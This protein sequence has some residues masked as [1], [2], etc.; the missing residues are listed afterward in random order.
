MDDG[1]LTRLFEQALSLTGAERRRFLDQLSSEQREQL[2]PL[3]QADQSAENHGLY[4]N[5]IAPAASPDP[6]DTAAMRN[7]DSAQITI[8]LPKQIGRYKI[9]QLIAEGGM[10]SVFMAEQTEPVKRRVALKIIKAGLD[11]E[12]V[13]ARFEAERQA[14]AMM[15]HAH[16]AKV[17][18]AGVTEEGLPFFVM[19]LVSGVSITTYC[20]E[21]RLNPEQR[22]RLFIQVCRAIQHAHQKGIIH[23]DIKPSN[24]LVTQAD[25]VPIPKVI[26]FGLAK[27]LQSDTLTDRTLFTHFGQVMGTLEYMSPEQAEMNSRDIDTRSDVYSLGVLLYELLTGSTPIGRER[28]RNEAFQQVMRLIREEE[29]QRPSLRLS[30]SGDAIIGI[31]EQRGIEPKQLNTI[32]RGDLDW[33]AVKALE[34]DRHR[35]YDGAAALASDVERFLN[36]EPIEAR[37][38]SFLYRLHKTWRRHR[39]AFASAAS[40]IVLLIAGLISTGTLWLRART[41]EQDATNQAAEAGR[42]KTAAIAET[43]KT[44]FALAQVEEERQRATSAQRETEAALARSDY[45]LAFTRWQARLFDESLRYLE[46]IPTEHRN[47]EWR[48]LRHTLEG[49]GIDCIGHNGL[50]TS[51][52]YSPDGNTLASG[53][54]DGTVRIWDTS[55]GDVLLTIPDHPTATMALSPDGTTLATAWKTI[56]FWDLRTGQQTGKLPEQSNLIDSLQ[57]NADGTQILSASRTATTLWSIANGTPIRSFRQDEPYFHQAVL[58]PDGRTIAAEGYSSLRTWDVES[59]KATSM[60]GRTGTAESV[61]FTPSG[62]AVAWINM[63]SIKVGEPASSRVQSVETYGKPRRLRV[64]PDGKYIGSVS[65]AGQIRIWH[66]HQL[67][68]LPALGQLGDGGLIEFSP[69][70]RRVACSSGSRIQIMPIMPP[71]GRKLRGRGSMMVTSVSGSPDGQL[72]AL[73]ESPFTEDVPKQITVWDTQRERMVCAIDA[74]EYRIWGTAFRNADEL[75][76]G[77]QTKTNFYDARS[78][79]LLRSLSQDTKAAPRIAISPDRQMLAVGEK[80]GDVSI[81][82]LSNNTIVRTLGIDEGVWRLTFSSDNRSMAV[83]NDSAISV[84]DVKSG[85][86]RQTLHPQFPVTLIGFSPTDDR[87][88]VAFEQTGE[89]EILSLDGSE[90]VTLDE[91][92]GIASASFSSDGQ[93]L[94]S[95]GNQTI[96]IYHAKSGE[97]LC[98]IKA[99]GGFENALLCGEAV[100]GVGSRGSITSWPVPARNRLKI[101]AGHKKDVFES[102]LSADGRRVYSSSRPVSGQELIVWDRASGEEI[103]DARWL[104]TDKTTSA[105]GRW[106]VAHAGKNVLLIDLEQ[107]N[108]PEARARRIADAR[109]NP[110]WHDARAT[111]AEREADWF[112]AAFHRA[113]QFKLQPASKAAFDKLH[114]AHA[115]LRASGTTV[116]PPITV[117]AL[118]FPEPDAP[119]E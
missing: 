116:I 95:A 75:A 18:D 22:L 28:V 21:A 11:T 118:K 48:W 81:W 60:F 110:Q 33:I 102:H 46:K 43:E 83:A 59:G 119:S 49:D 16:I 106:Q 26:D 90:S 96:R 13:T 111:L 19:E 67:V 79:K 58:S 84:W 94:L 15:A 31:S 89:L 78:G 66:R 62:N 17:F 69:D 88:V 92:R 74:P 34:K 54:N 91:H 3:L 32:V 2:E 101:L 57:F 39:L 87:L 44:K 108:S 104:R 105:D 6:G 82:D 40:L 23:R 50:I 45:R 71:L 14:M 1:Q 80:E 25:G 20:D 38:P 12:Q 99:S 56:S 41:A 117:E 47:I 35:R 107:W 24:V 114:Q 98:E 61:R 29:P 68:A 55:N 10:G 72:L 52:A 4:A 64:S 63:N 9:L 73:A 109:P 8:P 113:W 42:Q 36:D 77:L 37:P 51:L 100:F 70:S 97:Q 85:D 112:A 27:A 115:E 65:T 30:D 76:V 93:R 86:R 7:D 53:S 103:P 5:V